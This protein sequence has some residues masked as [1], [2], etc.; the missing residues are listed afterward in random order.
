MSGGSGA[1]TVRTMSKRPVQVLVLVALAIAGAGLTAGCDVRRPNTLEDGLSR[2]DAISEIR[3]AGGSGN[4]TIVGDSTT[5]VEV[6]RIARYRSAKPEQ[7]M[8]VAGSTLNLDTDCGLDCS[9]SYEVR[10]ARGVRV[11]GSNDSGNLTFEGVSDVDVRVGSGNIKVDGATGAVTV[12]AD[13]GNVELADVAGTL[14]ATVS[15]GNIKGRNLRGG[16]T[17]LKTD[18]GNIDISMPGTGDLEAAASSGNVKIRLPDRCCRILTS[19]SSGRVEV[20]VQQ[21]PQSTHLVDLTTDSG[22]IEVRRA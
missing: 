14:R 1:S 19:A 6:A 8:T 20:D 7:S 17:I 15:S 2:P 11:T 10:V 16:Q 5:G 13:S 9:A 18:S 22:N 3:I 4:V 21:D 12:E